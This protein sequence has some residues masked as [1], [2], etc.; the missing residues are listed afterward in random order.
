M[1]NVAGPRIE[2][3]IGAPVCLSVSVS[4]LF[5]GTSTQSILYSAEDRFESVKYSNKIVPL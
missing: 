2:P 4:F 1:D 5:Y 3:M